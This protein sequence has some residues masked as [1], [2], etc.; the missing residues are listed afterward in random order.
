MKKMSDLWQFVS[1]LSQQERKDLAV[2]LGFEGGESLLE[3]FST[4]PGSSV[5]EVLEWADE[6]FQQVNLDQL[7]D[8][9][10]GKKAGSLVA[11]LKVAQTELKRREVRVRSSEAASTTPIPPPAPH[12][13]E[14]E[15]DQVEPAELDEPDERA[16][17]AERV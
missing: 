8:A 17:L 16:E 13:P 6:L 12:S 10:P 14:V 11:A 7:D 15:P 9:V 5:T 4:S 3:R 1:A 2:D